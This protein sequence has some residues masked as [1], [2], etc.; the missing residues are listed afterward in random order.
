MPDEEKFGGVYT[1][2]GVEITQH[3]VAMCLPLCWYTSAAVP[4]GQLPHM[5][6]AGFNTHAQP[7]Y[8]CAVLGFVATASGSPH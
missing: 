5:F 2:S 4:H 3:R 8:A 1:A 6:S 7:F